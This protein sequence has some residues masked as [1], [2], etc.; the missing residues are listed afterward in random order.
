MRIRLIVAILSLCAFLSACASPSATQPPTA[1][2]LPTAVVQATDAVVP[3]EAAPVV[4]AP[5]DTPAPTANPLTFTIAGDQS[6][7][8]FVIGEILAG[9]P[10]TVVGVTHDV[11]GTFNVDYADTSSVS[12]SPV[13][14][15]MST[16]ATDNPFRNRTLQDS[17][18]QTSSPANRYAEF[19]PKSV[20][21][22]P[23]TVVIGTAYKVEVTGD[24]AMHGVGKELTFQGTVTPVSATQVTG[25]LSVQFA[26]ADFGIQ[27]LRLPQQ[28]ASVEDL[29]TLELEFVANTP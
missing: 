9:Q 6:E 28:V 24:M 16:L 23:A 18:L 13:K 19:T 8:R 20:N 2:V 26:Y 3:T 27:I 14:V 29:V 22:L 15:D 7:A 11:E 25:L 10:N 4:T 12:F 17:I 1:A 5:P 21:G